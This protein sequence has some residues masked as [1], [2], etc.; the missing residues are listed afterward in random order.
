M[1]RLAYEARHCSKALFGTDLIF[2]T[3]GDGAIYKARFFGVSQ[4][5][6]IGT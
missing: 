3:K 6:P 4:I 2:A 1:G 5:Q